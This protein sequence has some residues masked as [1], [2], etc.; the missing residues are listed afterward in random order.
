MLNN[1]IDMRAVIIEDEIVAAE[2]LKDLVMQIDDTVEIVAVLQT[3]EDSV[4]WL[5]N[6]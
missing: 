2:S 1:F 5:E 3:I 4:E 6:N